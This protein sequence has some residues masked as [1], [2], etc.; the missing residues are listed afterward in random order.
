MFSWLAPIGQALRPLGLPIG[1]I[2]AGIVLGLLLY[3]LV[4]SLRNRSATEGAGTVR[5]SVVPA[6]PAGSP[7]SSPAHVW[8]ALPRQRPGVL[9][10]PGG[11]DPLAGRRRAPIRAGPPGAAVRGGAHRHVRRPLRPA[12]PLLS[13]FVRKVRPPC[14]PGRHLAVLAT[15]L[16]G[17][18]CGKRAHPRDSRLHLS[19][20]PRVHGRVRRGLGPGGQPAALHTPPPT[21]RARD[22]R[23]LRGSGVNPRRSVLH[24][25]GQ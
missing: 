20:V 7:D 14:R 1:A 13:H 22:G 5:V 3:L 8:G 6:G 15:S 17:D 4:Q 23:G 12:P 16:A 19:D 24:D 25:P 2:V 9:P 10:R 11:R 21:S 18:L